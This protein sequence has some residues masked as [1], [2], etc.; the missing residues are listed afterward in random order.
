MPIVGFQIGPKR[1]PQ[2]VRLPKNG[3]TEQTQNHY[4]LHSQ[5]GH[6]PKKENVWVNLNS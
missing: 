5:I 2:G 3:Q 4:V 1:N 6:I